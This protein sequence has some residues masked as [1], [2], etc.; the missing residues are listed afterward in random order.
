MSVKCDS[1]N[2]LAAKAHHCIR[3]HVLL[4]PTVK[5]KTLGN[6]QPDSNVVHHVLL[7]HGHPATVNRCLDSAPYGICSA[8]N[9]M[10]TGNDA[11]SHSRHVLEAYSKF[12]LVDQTKQSPAVNPVQAP[13]SLLIGKSNVFRGPV[14][15][16]REG[17]RAR[18]YSSAGNF[19]LTI[20]MNVARPVTCAAVMR[21][22]FR[23]MT[24][25][26]VI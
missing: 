14:H 11:P 5:N 16:P 18:V 20:S 4:F 12:L 17:K 2:A 21:T 26:G 15:Q 8:F 3:H 22:S 13:A 1:L 19:L 6:V 10:G 25:G 7:R 23:Y 24:M 9:G